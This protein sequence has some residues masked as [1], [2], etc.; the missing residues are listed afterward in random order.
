M[1]RSRTHKRKRRLRRSV[2]RRR[3]M[4]GGA[5]EAP[6]P[7]KPKNISNTVSQSTVS[8][9]TVSQSTVSQST[10]SQSTVSQST[11]SQST[12]SQ[13]TVSQAKY[14]QNGGEPQAEFLQNSD[15][16]LVTPGTIIDFVVKFTP[17]ISAEATG[18]K[19]TV[20]ETAHSPQCTLPNDSHMYSI[21]CWDPD[22]QVGK[23]FLHWLVVNCKGDQDSGKT[24]CSWMGPSPP[25]G[26]GMHRYIIGL[27]KQNV[28]INAESIVDRTNFNATT[29][30]T[31][32]NITPMSYKGFRVQSPEGPKPV[33]PPPQANNQI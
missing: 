24:L 29:Y 20:Y 11:V 3:N 21:I 15:A 13:S 31:Q 17:S 10:V 5:Y 16:P 25:P 1:A 28:A 32:N 14:E 4:R 7:I 9:S 19:R 6:V 12:V 8:Q 23:S 27:F 30:A 2:K 26:S 18:P 22:I 33:T